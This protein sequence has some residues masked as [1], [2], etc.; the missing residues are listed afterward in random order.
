VNTS[1]GRLSI[2]FVFSRARWRWLMERF[3]SVDTFSVFIAHICQSEEVTN[4]TQLSHERDILMMKIGCR[5]ESVCVCGVWCGVMVWWF[6]VMKMERFDVRKRSLTSW[7]AWTRGILKIRV[8]LMPLNLDLPQVYTNKNTLR[9]LFKVMLHPPL[10]HNQ[11]LM[12]L[13]AGSRE[14]IVFVWKP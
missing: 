7:G 14:R 11:N 9:H 12:M 3:R 10:H 5:D 2:N 6:M 8:I 1:L 13:V 4:F